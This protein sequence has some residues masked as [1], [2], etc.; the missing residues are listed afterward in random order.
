MSAPDAL[1]LPLHRHS[2]TREYTPH[3][4]KHLGSG[5]F[6]AVYRATRI[7]DGLA[8]AVKVIKLSPHAWQEVKMHHY[9]TLHAPDH[10]VNLLDVYEND[11]VFHTDSSVESSAA[12]LHEAAAGPRVRHVLIVME[13]MEGGDLLR[14][15]RD[16]GDTFN[17]KMASCVFRGV[18]DAVAALHRLN[19]AHRDIKPENILF[20]LAHTSTAPPS[21]EDSTAHALDSQIKVKLCDFAFAQFDGQLR[22]ECGTPEYQA[23]ETMLVTASPIRAFRGP[24]CGRLAQRQQCY[25]KSCDMWSLGA[26]LYLMVSGTLPFAGNCSME[27]KLTQQYEFQPHPWASLSKG[28]KQCVSLLLCGPP[29]LRLT[30]EKLLQHPW[31]TQEDN[32]LTT[33]PLPT[34]S[35]TRQSSEFLEGCMALDAQNTE[36]RVDVS[37][38]KWNRIEREIPLGA[39]GVDA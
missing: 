24:A 21:S 31:I 4:D 6:G 5:T 17:E 38:N 7:S 15:I 26:V 11:L 1:P 16:L 22:E 25:T 34:S 27:Q 29:R 9:L 8:C 37:A 3:W 14:R 33:H 2:I 18:V 12:S 39:F 30:A 10:V 32:D 13:L 28:A 35:L 23:P 36:N 20:S 19:I